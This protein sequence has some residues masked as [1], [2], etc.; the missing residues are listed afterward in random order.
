MDNQDV[1]KEFQALIVKHLDESHLLQGMWIVH[2]DQWQRNYVL[3][4]LTCS[5]I[6]ISHFLE[7]PLLL[8]PMQ[9]DD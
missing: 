4:L 9:L 3:A 6:E 7:I 1:S 8:F 2:A 5:L